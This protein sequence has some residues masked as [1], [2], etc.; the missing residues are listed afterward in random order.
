MVIPIVFLLWPN[1]ALHYMCRLE[2]SANFILYLFGFGW[3]IQAEWYSLISDVNKDL[4]PKAKD[5]GHKAK[6]F[7]YQG[8]R[9][10]FQSQ[11]EALDMSKSMARKKTKAKITK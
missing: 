6:A 11:G 2:F 3:T 5:R 8:Q 10:E 4:G 7:K 1:I 9:L